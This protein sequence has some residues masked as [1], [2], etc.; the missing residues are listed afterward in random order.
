MA[1]LSKEEVT[2][3]AAEY[4]IDLTGLSWP[5]QQKAIMGYEREHGLQKGHQGGTG[6]NYSQQEIELAAEAMVNRVVM[7]EPSLEPMDWRDAPIPQEPVTIVESTLHEIDQDLRRF[8]NTT[9][10]VTPEI[11]ANAQRALLYDEELGDELILE[12]SSLLEEFE[13]GANLLDGYSDGHR[14]ET[15]R[16]KGKTG[17]KVVGQGM[18]PK[19]GAQIAFRPAYDLFPVARYDGRYGYLW[20]HHRLPNVKATLMQ[21]GYYEKYKKRFTDSNVMSY[22]TNLLV[23]DINA[24]HAIFKEIEEEEKRKRQGNKAVSEQADIIARAVAMA[25]KETNTNG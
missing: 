24:T 10:L 22:I 13:R 18:A 16:I 23:V 11:K 2:T 21:S 4:G 19:R 17:R 9:I 3:K 12:E 1:F 25:L 8:R 7:E 14:S 5:Q 6:K 15:Y 20:T